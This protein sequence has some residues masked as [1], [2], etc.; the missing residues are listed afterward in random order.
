[1]YLWMYKLRAEDNFQMS[2]SSSAWGF[3][4]L[5]NTIGLGCSHFITWII[6]LDPEDWIFMKIFVNF[7]AEEVIFCG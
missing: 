5:N 2:L 1:M 3:Q 6:L 7:Q 4:R